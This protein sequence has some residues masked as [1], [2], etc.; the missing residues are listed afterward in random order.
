MKIGTKNGHSWKVD[1]RVR[2]NPLVTKSVISGLF[3]V[4]LELF[5]KF[6]GVGFDLIRPTFWC[7]FRFKG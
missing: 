2:Y 6:L 4:A 1:T 5:R 3:R 7:A